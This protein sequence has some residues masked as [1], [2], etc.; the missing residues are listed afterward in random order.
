MSKFDIADKYRAQPRVSPHETP[1]SVELLGVRIHTLRRDELLEQIAT[2]IAARQRA[3]ISYANVHALNLAY[4]LP[5]FRALLNQSDLVFCDGFGVKWGA[6]LVGAR[7]PERFTPPDWIA[8]LVEIACR[9]DFSVFMVGARAGVAERVATEF[10]RRFPDLRIAGTHHG[11]FDKTPNSAEN[12]AVI[13]A[14]NAA[15]PNLLIVGF[16]M[17]IQE[18]WLLD[19]WARLDVNVALTAGA[20]FDYLAGEVR[21]APRWMTDH[22]LEGLGRLV[23]EPRRLWRRYLVGNPLFLY[24]VLRQR[25]GLLRLE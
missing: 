25:L 20:A 13:Q 10:K 23:I 22:G 16:G 3:L 15:K 19:N 1:D 14:I 9:D 24:R 7:L 8:R 6:R 12:Q 4:S 2:V 17:P 5:W 21:R 11:Y 18:R